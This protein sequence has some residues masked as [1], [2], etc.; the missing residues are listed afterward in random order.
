MRDGQV[1]QRSYAHESVLLP[2]G[3]YLIECLANL[4]RL[5]T[6]CFFMA[7]PLKIAAGSGSPLRA[8]A[9]TYGD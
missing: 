8:V 3:V 6:R 4:D 7:L 1:V 2:R 5:P 9:V